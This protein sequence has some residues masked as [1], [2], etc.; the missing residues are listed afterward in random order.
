MLASLNANCTD[1]ALET[2]LTQTFSRF[3][4]CWSK[5]RRNADGIPFAFVQFKVSILSH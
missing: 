5:V 4:K 3:G 1:V 2:A